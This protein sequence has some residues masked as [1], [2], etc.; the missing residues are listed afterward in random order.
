MRAQIR[1][2]PGPDLIGRLD[3]VDRKAP[4]HMVL[5]DWKQMRR[6]RRLSES[7]RVDALHAGTPHEPRDSLCADAPAIRR[8]LS[9]NSRTAVRTSTLTM[10]A[11]E[12]VA[13]VV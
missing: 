9:M 5:R 8:E 6:V 7:A 2:V 3:L 4:P 11:H 13:P 1:Y 10:R 12:E